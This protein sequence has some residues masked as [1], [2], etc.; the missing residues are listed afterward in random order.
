MVILFWLQNKP[1]NIYT[2]AEIVYVLLQEAK[3]MFLFG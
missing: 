2:R 1:K 3:P